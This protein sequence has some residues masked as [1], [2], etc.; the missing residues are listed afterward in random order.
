[1]THEQMLDALAPVRLPSSFGSLGVNEI[2]VLV[3][4]GLI[5]GV[6]VSA[7]IRPLTRGGDRRLRLSD[8][9]AMP[10]PQRMLALSRL[11]GHLPPA[12][13]PAAYGAATPPS[14]R[15]IERIARLSRLRWRRWG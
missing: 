15:R 14:D 7:I 13:R 10:V 6:A 4:L 5:V 8:L 1:M 12:L 2:M 11:L 3:A 9:R